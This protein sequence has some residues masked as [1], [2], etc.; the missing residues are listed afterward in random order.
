[1]MSTIISQ[2]KN[3]HPGGKREKREK[4]EQKNLMES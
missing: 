2:K 3:I 4:R 1:M